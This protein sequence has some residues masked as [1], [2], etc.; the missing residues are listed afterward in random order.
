MADREHEDSLQQYEDWKQRSDS[1]DETAKVLF[2]QISHIGLCLSYDL[3]DKL[4]WWEKEAAKLSDEEID[5][6][7]PQLSAFLAQLK[8]A[9]LTFAEMDL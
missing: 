8:T 1:G 9:Y 2:R 7:I 6:R 4:R 3:I 5:Q